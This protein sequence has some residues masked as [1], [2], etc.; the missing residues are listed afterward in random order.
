MSAVTQTEDYDLADLVR[1]H[2][3]GVWRYLRFLGADPSEAEDLVQETFLA[4][5]RAKFVYQGP[6]ATAAYLRQ[7]ARNQLLQVRRRQGR[8]VNT[9]EIAAAESVW[10]E[11][12][13]ADGL[14]DYLQALEGCLDG[15][16]DRSRQ[17]VELQY[18]KGLGRAEIAEHMRMSVDGVKTLLRRT[19]HRLR[20]CVER[21]VR[22]SE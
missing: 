16:Q 11:F 4:F 17:A 3:A 5:M 22:R 1:M 10:A 13:A 14:D 2:Q 6:T 20:E 7:V 19:R 21:K 8:E 9:V 15:L 18:R 12:A